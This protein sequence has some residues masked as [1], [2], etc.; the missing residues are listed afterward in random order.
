[1]HETVV[2]LIGMKLATQYSELDEQGFTGLLLFLILYNSYLSSYRYRIFNVSVMRLRLHFTTTRKKWEV[3]IQACFL[4][5][6]F[7]LKTSVVS[8]L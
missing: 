2:V 1:M 7:N 4:A 8:S 5:A 6:Y 3:Y